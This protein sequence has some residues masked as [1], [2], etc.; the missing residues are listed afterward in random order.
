MHGAGS[1]SAGRR[2]C[3]KGACKKPRAAPRAGANFAGSAGG[4]HPPLPYPN[5]P[6]AWRGT[7]AENDNSTFQKVLRAHIQEATIMDLRDA[8][9]KSY[10][11]SVGFI[12]AAIVLIAIMCF[13]L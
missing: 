7:T 13:L 10:W 4:S 3:R 11:V 12:A 1:S 6:N 2:T 8:M 9:G 5:R